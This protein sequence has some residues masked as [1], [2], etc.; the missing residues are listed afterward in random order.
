M[1]ELE[2]ENSSQICRVSFAGL[3]AEWAHSWLA[4]CL[5]PEH[6]GSLPRPAALDDGSMEQTEPPADSTP[7]ASRLPLHSNV[8][9][10]FQFPGLLQAV[11]ALCTV[12]CQG[13]EVAGPR[14][15]EGFPLPALPVAFLKV[16]KSVFLSHPPKLLFP[17]NSLQLLQN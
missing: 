13:G 15:L 1:F 5:W 11:S 9:S 10:L 8:P 4:L 3:Q 7:E 6:G 12:S 16:T 17:M 2:P 14:Q